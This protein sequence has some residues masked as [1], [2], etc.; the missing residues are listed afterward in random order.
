LKADGH[1]VRAFVRQKDAL[2]LRRLRRT[3][4]VE[5]RTEFDATFARELRSISP[6]LIVSWFWTR[7][8]PRHILAIAPAIGVHPSLL[9]RWRGPDPYFWAIASGDAIT[10]V[11]AHHLDEN[12]DTG[13]ILGRRELAIDP[14]WNSWILARKLD[15]PSLALLREVVM[16]F[17]RGAPPRAVPQDESLV[18]HAPAP[19][20]LEIRW[21]RTSA[22]IERFIRAAAPYPG[23]FTDIGGETIV[24]TKAKIMEAPKSLNPGE[25]LVREGLAIVRTADSGLALV[26]G[27]REA[28]ES[29]LDEKAL[30]TLVANS[31]Q[32]A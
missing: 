8:L 22:E 21:S 15:R 10:G 11:T 20:D 24:V 13:P 7:Q 29:P 27:H 5:I 14:S 3:C 18:T 1:D 31:M 19:K 17:A 16:A 25:A 26:G 12:Y 4:P 6:G 28:D 23:A 30:A 9:P 32:S 2:G